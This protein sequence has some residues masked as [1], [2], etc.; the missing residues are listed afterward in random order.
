MNINDIT[1]GQV[2]ELQGLLAS[3]KPNPL[4]NHSWQIGEKYVVRTMVYHIIGEL[5]EVTETDLY[6]EPAAWLAVGTRM[7]HMLKT[8]DVDEVEPFIHGAW[9]S[10]ASVCDWTPWQHAIPTEAK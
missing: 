10:R 1:L 5:R 6:F 2:L 3:C 9:V 7:S 8:G 4:K